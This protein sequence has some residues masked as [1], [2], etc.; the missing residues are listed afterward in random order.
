M[1]ISAQNKPEHYLVLDS[2]RGVC[3]IMVALFHYRANSHIEDLA[4]IRNS[5]LFV[6]FF[7][8][9]SGFVIA[10]NYREKLLSGKVSFGKFIWLRFARLYPL[11]LFMLS[12]FVI[13]EIAISIAYQHIGADR[14]PFTGGRSLALIPENVFLLQS[15]GFSGIP[16]WNIPAWSIS[17]EFWTYMI[18]ALLLIFGPSMRK[19]WVL[20][21]LILAPIAILF[22]HHGSLALE[23]DGGIIRCLFGFGI[24]SLVSQFSLHQKPTDVG[25][26][27][28]EIPLV[29]LLLGFICFAPEWGITFFAPILFAITLIVFAKGTGHVSSF[30][31]HRAF[32][33]LGA[34]SY[35]IYM[36]H[37]Y[38]HARMKNVAIIAEKVTNQ[39]YF[40]DAESRFFGPNAWAGDI[41]VLTALTLTITASYITWRYIEMPSQTYLRGMA[42]IKRQKGSAQ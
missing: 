11:H 16:S 3:A 23:F 24:G 32:L 4:L 27:V 25:T 15:L 14:T 12:L 20:F 18:F 41:F 37:T 40:I 34:L 13:T 39:S 30:L 9:L 10:E 26:R 5:W 1:S 36:V 7:F 6:D 17:A 2:L 8:V 35:S 22:L 33:L 19:I 31:K 28:S 42:F 29:A 38:L 21:T